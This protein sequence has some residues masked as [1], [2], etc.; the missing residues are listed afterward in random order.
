MTRL[1]I[2]TTSYKTLHFMVPFASYFRAKGWRVDAIAKDAPG[3]EYADPFDR[4]WNIT[5]SRNPLS[6]PQLFAA[7]EELRNV[8]AREHYDL[9]HVHTPVASFVARYALRNLRQRDA[10]K[11]IYTAHGFHFHR[12]QSK[13]KN[14]IFITLEKLAGRW[15]DYLIVINHEDE[16]AAQKY[17]LVPSARVHYMPG[18]GIDTS[19]YDP[20]CV[21]G[22]EIARVR[23]ELH[24][25][26]ETH[27]FLMIGEFNPGKWHSQALQAL[28]Q[29]ERE[30]VH[31]AF[32]G[33]GRLMEAMK[34]LAIQ[35]GIDNRVHFLGWRNDIPAI[36]RASVATILP[37]E[38]EGLPRSVMESLSLEVPVIGADVRGI[39]DLLEDGTGILFEAGDVDALAHAMTWILDHPDQ[40]RAMGAQGRVKMAGHD[41]R[42]ILMLHEALYR[43]A[44]GQMERESIP[45]IAL[46]PTATDCTEEQG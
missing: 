15:T 40:A 14:A 23:E 4:V 46:E 12:G 2:V 31:L 30:D 43:E 21:S 34:K 33:I 42:S 26:P 7:A 44:L 45:Y 6:F 19:Y 37:S 1:L 20:V 16:E 10:L 38:R 29:I 22:A 28:S 17:H 27:L 18:I 5:W 32:A 41:I 11:V 36:V 24:L 39:R 9:V 35:L 25:S 13:S 3:S 8:V